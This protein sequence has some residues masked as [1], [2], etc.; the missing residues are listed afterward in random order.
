MRVAVITLVAGR[1]R[2]LALQQR[3][4]ARG[5]RPPDHYV[6]VAMGDP[7]AAGVLRGRSP[8]ADVVAVPRADG[9]ALPLAAARNAGARRALEGGAELLVFLDVDCVP[10]PDLLTRYADVAEDGALLCGT[11]AYLPPPPA[12]GYRLD[13]LSRLAPPHPGR[14]APSKDEV[15]AGGDHRL[16]W[17]LSFAVT[18]ATWRRIG[19]FCEGY[20]GYGG[21]DTDFARAAAARDVDL[22]WV[23]GAPAHHQYHPVSRPPVE[24]L[25]DILRNGALFHSRWGEWPMEG[26]LRDFARLGLVSHDDRT[27]S[28]HRREPADTGR[29]GPRPPG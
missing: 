7:D 17:S 19:G 5:A 15:L 26:W 3:G 4:L 14:P 16:F 24:H 29:P 6:V 11:V 9:G 27:G 21:E 25:E 18:A 20:V 13:E 22:W 2:H 23:G 28:W 8:A 1:H 12:G 10:G